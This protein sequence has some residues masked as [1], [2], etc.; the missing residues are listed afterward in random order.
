MQEQ[1]IQV[2]FHLLLRMAADLGNY[3]K[4]QFTLVRIY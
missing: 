1:N 3:A 4:C 2:K